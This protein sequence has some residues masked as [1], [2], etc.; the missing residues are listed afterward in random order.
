MSAI[1]T[2]VV[3]KDAVDAAFC[4]FVRDPLFPCLAGKGV[5]NSNGNEMG[6]YDALGSSRSTRE[7]SRDLGAFVR[8]IAAEDAALRTFVAVFPGAIAIEESAFEHQLWT[9]LQRLHDTEGADA[10]WDAAVSDD[11]D[12]PDFSFSHAG[13]ALF[14]V[15]LHP[16]SSR[17]ARRFRWPTLVFNPRAQF[18][19][20]RADGKFERLR[21]LVR[22]REIA[23]QGTL[24][25]NLADFGER[26]EARQYSGRATEQDWQCPFHRQQK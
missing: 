17:M 5:V 16:R 15:G 8:T 12:D 25:P 18:E 26:S 2:T 22:E 20:L 11:P 23:L 24:N 19:R 21:G 4:E 7:L 13:C 6:V 10:P 3:T 14:V 9:Q 1:H